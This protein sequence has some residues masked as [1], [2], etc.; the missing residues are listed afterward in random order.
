MSYINDALLST[1]HHK[2]LKEE[3]K[4]LVDKWDKTGLLEGLDGD[5]NKS[6]MAIL[7]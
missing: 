3:S 7:L 1:N 6:G 5:Y 4:G 2:K